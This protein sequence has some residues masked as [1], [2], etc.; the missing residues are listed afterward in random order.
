MAIHRLDKRDHYLRVDNAVFED[1]ELSWEAR[2]LLGYLLTKPDQW[3]V[4][5]HDLV[6]HGPARMKKVKR[7]LAELEE[8]GYLRRWRFRREDGSFEWDAEVYESPGPQ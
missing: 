8:H 2:G 6:A 7:M 1:A 4:R 5:I 3:Q